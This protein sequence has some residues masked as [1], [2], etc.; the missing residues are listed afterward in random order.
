M[1]GIF[2]LIKNINFIINKS[3]VNNNFNKGQSRGPEHSILSVIN[4]QLMFGFH[5]LAIN[6]LDSIS[7]QPLVYDGV[8]LICNGEI[9]NYKE[10]YSMLDVTPKSNSDCEAI[11]HMYLKYGIEYT[12]QN[13]DGVFSFVLNDSNSKTGYIADR[14]SVV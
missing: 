14:K 9:Y 8:Y 10:I 2:A 1:C 13:L 3:F 12:L 7:N 6:G 4:E 5:R 11:L